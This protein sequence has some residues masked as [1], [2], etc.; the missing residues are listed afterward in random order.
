VYTFELYTY[1]SSKFVDP[2]E[3]ILIT[4]TWDF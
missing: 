1:N 4:K 3:F 2:I